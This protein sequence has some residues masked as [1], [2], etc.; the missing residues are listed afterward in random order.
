MTEPSE[1]ADTGRL[2]VIS[3]PSGSGKTTVC[4][5]LLEDPGVRHS[6]SATTRR[7][8]AGETDGEHYIFLERDAFEQRVQRGEFAE[9]AEYN[10]QLYGTPRGPLEQLLEQGF[11]VLVEIDVQGAVQM[12]RL[13]PDATYIFLDAP[14]GEAMARLERRNT[15]SAEDRRRRAEAAKRERDAA[16]QAHFDHTVINDD[17]DATVAKIRELIAGARPVAKN[18]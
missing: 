11:R 8:R 14:A 13:Y 7:P 1:H 18:T 2:V 3:G 12:R 17:L 5:R 16:Q 4:R 10:G 9:Y 6:V 15:E